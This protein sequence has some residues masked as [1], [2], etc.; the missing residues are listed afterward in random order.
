VSPCSQP[1]DSI[2]LPPLTK[3]GCFREFEPRQRYLSGETLT[4]FGTTG[5]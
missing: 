4:T 2:K 3:Q 1:I 5:I